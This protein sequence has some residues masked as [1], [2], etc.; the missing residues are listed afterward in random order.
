[1]AVGSQVDTTYNVEAFAIP[2]VP[3]PRH[4]AF[5]SS[6]QERHNSPDADDHFNN[7]GQ[8]PISCAWG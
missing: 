2:N 5:E 7:E 1:M 6:S 8:P 3:G 4:R